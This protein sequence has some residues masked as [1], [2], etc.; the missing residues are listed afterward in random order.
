M[1]AERGLCF[2]ALTYVIKG[3]SR[4][5]VDA[6]H[7]R[8]GMEIMEKDNA[9]L[10]NKLKQSRQRLQSQEHTLEDLQSKLQDSLSQQRLLEIKH[11]NLMIEQKELQ[12]RLM[13]ALSCRGKLQ[14]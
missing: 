11:S 1:S 4:T 7:I 14:G 10:Q 3:L 9:V 13:Y 6:S 8:L 12:D 2:E 5:C